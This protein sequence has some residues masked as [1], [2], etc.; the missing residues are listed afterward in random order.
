MGVQGVGCG[1]RDCL[2]IVMTGR[3]VRKAGHKWQGPFITHQQ[4]QLQDLE[5]ALHVNVR[6]SYESAGSLKH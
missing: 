2:V 5:N 6:R 1:T 4:H 3:P